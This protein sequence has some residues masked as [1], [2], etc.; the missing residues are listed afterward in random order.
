MMFM[1]L[2]WCP[3]WIR[4]KL[5]QCASGRPVFLILPFS[6]WC[7]AAEG[8]SLHRLSTLGRSFVLGPRLFTLLYLHHFPFIVN[9]LRTLSIHIDHE[10]YHLVSRLSG[11]SRV[12]VLFA[13]LGQTCKKCKRPEEGQ[14]R[15][16]K[17]RQ[18]QALGKWTLGD[19]R[20]Q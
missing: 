11:E 8:I 5:F 12:G 15:D 14:G 4:L 19:W 9:L 1:S 18:G 6:H 16:G 2:S 3:T 13:R 7:F 20:Q 10:E 17:G